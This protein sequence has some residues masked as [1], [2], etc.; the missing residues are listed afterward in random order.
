MEGV[1]SNFTLGGTSLNL[2]V[3]GTEMAQ[4]PDLRSTF[5]FSVY[6]VH[7]LQRLL[8]SCCH[9]EL[10]RGE[11]YIDVRPA[12]QR[13]GTKLRCVSYEECLIIEP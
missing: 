13:Y 10:Q 12:V 9:A 11:G 7:L 6:S 5:V 3:P 1:I 2:P 8:S 4:S